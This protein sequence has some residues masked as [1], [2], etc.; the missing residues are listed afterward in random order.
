MLFTYDR[1]D[2]CGYARS[3]CMI[4][5][6]IACLRDDGNDGGGMSTRSESG[7]NLASVCKALPKTSRS[8]C[9]I[10]PNL[11]YSMHLR[12]QPRYCSREL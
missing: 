7:K 5:W 12:L 4:S 2:M 11:S 8:L 10:G 6:I 3:M 9:S 1:M